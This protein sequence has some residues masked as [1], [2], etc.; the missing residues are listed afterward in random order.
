ML[1]KYSKLYLGAVL[2]SMIAWICTI[3]SEGYDSDQFNLFFDGCGNFLA[4][5]TN[6]CGYSFD[7]DVYNN[8]VNGYGQK[9]YPPLPYVLTHIFSHLDV[10][11]PAY[12]NL[13][14]QPRFLMIYI[15]FII[16]SIVTINHI[17]TANVIGGD[18]QKFLSSLAIIFS[19][20]M[21]YAIERGNLILLTFMFVMIYLFY[22]D[23][24]SK[25]QRELSLLSLGIAVG[26]KLSPLILVLLLIYDK[27]FGDVIKVIAYSVV[28]F[29]TPFYYFKGGIDNVWLMFRNMEEFFEFYVTGESVYESISFS[30]IF[31]RLMEKLYVDNVKIEEWIEFGQWFSFIISLLFILTAKYFERK[32]EKILAISL[33]LIL[34]PKITW[35]YCML[36]LIPA[37]VMFLNESK[38][39]SLDVL[40]LLGFILMCWDYGFS[41]VW[42]IVLCCQIAI[43]MF[44]L[45]CMI[46]AFNTV[47]ILY[48]R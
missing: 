18:M 2:L 20:V 36:Y 30:G 45:Y 3:L 27:R 38:R 4:D 13:Y 12:T 9:A 43:V 28:L 15:L 44:C 1:D 42:N 39:Q 22:Y 47:R 6:V 14:M 24:K 17:I 21:I 46:R 10:V 34:V 48:K 7:K 37:L 11:G 35:L 25:I 23:S 26:L 32:F 29:I 8:E 19:S 31:C 5:F 41:S 33:V 40:C 16:M